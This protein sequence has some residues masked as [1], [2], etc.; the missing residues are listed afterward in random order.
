MTWDILMTS[1]RSKVAL[2]KGRFYGNYPK[3]SQ[4]H[5]KQ[6]GF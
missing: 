2:A 1:T 5:P 3:S 6:A 4:A